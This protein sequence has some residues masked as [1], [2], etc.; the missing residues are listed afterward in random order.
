MYLTTSESTQNI[1]N[2]T[3]EVHLVSLPVIADHPTLQVNADR[4]TLPVNADRPIFYLSSS[5]N[6]VVKSSELVLDL[7]S[8]LESG[9][10][11]VVIDYQGQSPLLP[12]EAP[13]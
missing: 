7:V 4:P 6:V 13:A 11:D 12:Y 1:K 2:E 3:C 8:A 5:S 9:L 10:F